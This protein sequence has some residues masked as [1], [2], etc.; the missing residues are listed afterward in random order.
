MRKLIPLL[1]LLLL[2]P[3]TA[4]AEG[5]FAEIPEEIRPGKSVRLTLAADAPADV[6]VLEE[7]S[8]IAVLAEDAQPQDGEIRLY[9]DGAD[10]AGEPLPAGA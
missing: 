2:L 8:I 10:D 1:T 7:G 5:L 9:W 4:P 3:L 6:T